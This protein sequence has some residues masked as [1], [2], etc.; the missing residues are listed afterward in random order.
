M[1]NTETIKIP[2]FL[3]KKILLFENIKNSYEVDF[4]ESVDNELNW[5][6]TQKRYFIILKG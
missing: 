2:Y 1:T 5:L 4:N 3:S 6:N